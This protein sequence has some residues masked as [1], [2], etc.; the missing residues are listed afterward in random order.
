MHHSNKN[1]IVKTNHN[2]RGSCNI[3]YSLSSP[4]IFIKLESADLKNHML[5]SFMIKLV[6]R[7][8]PGLKKTYNSIYV[9]G[10]KHN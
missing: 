10:L 6:C 5:Y 7:S 3:F 2:F 4:L 8:P 1:I 9:F